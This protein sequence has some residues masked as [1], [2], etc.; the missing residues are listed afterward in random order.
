MQGLETHQTQEIEVS[1]EWS[2]TRHRIER[3]VWT[4]EK[5][6]KGYKGLQ[7]LEKHQTQDIDIF[8][9]CSHTRHGI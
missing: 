7:E 1:T 8:T 6:D 3:I 4:R 9:D 2:H 5:P